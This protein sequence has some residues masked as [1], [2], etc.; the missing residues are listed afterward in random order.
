M[1]YRK[2]TWYKYMMMSD[3]TVKVDICPQNDLKYE[4]MELLSTGQLTTRQGYAWDG[5]TGFPM[6]PKML[7]RASLVHDT[8]YQLMRLGVLDPSTNRILVD[9]TFK[10]I[11]LEDGVPRIIALPL[12][13]ATRLF[14]WILLYRENKEV[15]TY[16]AP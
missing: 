16:E 14:G 10:K 15:A 9:R 1:E 7:L 5:A 2:L 6:T 3:Y 11:C 13:L 4:F 12:Y 8:L